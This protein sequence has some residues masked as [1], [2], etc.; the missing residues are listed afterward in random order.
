MKEHLTWPPVA[1]MLL[2]SIILTALIGVVVIGR[3]AS[4]FQTHVQQCATYLAEEQRKASILGAITALAETD[5][6]IR[7]TA[8]GRLEPDNPM[9]LRQMERIF[10]RFGL[11]NMMVMA[12][13][14][15]VNAYR[16][17]NVSTSI[18]GKNFAWRPYFTGP[19][20]GM[21]TM[22]AAFGSNSLE[23]GFYVSTPLLPQSESNHADRKPIGVIVAKLGF[24]EIDRLLSKQ[25]MP[26]AVM[27]PEGVVF[28]SNVPDWLYQVIGT[29]DQLN[30]A[31]SEK[32]VNNAYREKDP[33]LIPL[34]NDGNIRHKGK[35]LS[36]HTTDISWPDPSG[37]WLLAGFIN[38]GDL[39]SWPARITTTTI[40]FLFSLLLHTWL[41]VRQQASRRTK[42]VVTLL[43]N[44]GEGFLSFG[45]DL[46][47]DSEYSRACET[48]LGSSPAGKNVVELLFDDAP[49]SDE[50]M[51]KTIASVITT[52]DSFISDS[53]LSLLPKEVKRNNTLLSI[54]YRRIAA[55]KFMIILSD[56]TEQRATEERLHQE[57][58]R[59]RM[60]VLA[61]S[62]SRNFFETVESFQEFLDHLAECNLAD[63]SDK[64]GLAK[65]IY[66]ELHTFKGTLNQ[67][68]F[69]SVPEAIHTSE[70][71]LALLLA[72]KNRSIITN[73]DIISRI[74]LQQL[75]AS[76]G[77]DLKVLG[78]TLGSDFLA[79]GNALVLSDEQAEQLEAFVQKLL[80]GEQLD[81]G[82]ADVRK[83]LNEIRNLR[84]VSLTS[85][86]KGFGSLVEQA[87]KRLGKQ[88]KP[89]QLEG[90]D[91][92]L[93]D[94]QLYK[95]FLQSLVHIFRNAVSH[96]IEDPEVRWEHNKD[97]AGSISCKAVILNN[98]LKLTISDDGAGLD[99]DKLAKKAVELKLPNAE[100]M[101]REELQELIF[102]DQ[103]STQNSANE[104]AGRGVGLAAVRSETEKLGGRVTVDSTTGVGTSFSFTLPFTDIGDFTK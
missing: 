40:I 85:A 10:N 28:A 17:K 35:T 90:G 84:K 46:T 25:K 58:Q 93:I 5:Q 51:R 50:L 69:T 1:A 2:V 33:T 76:L 92:I 42:Q 65:N 41:R 72:D 55:E 9:V 81:T 68:S 96:G 88:I 11:D 18:T 27:S 64:R 78:D 71:G 67:Y 100:N 80:R 57:Q 4:E 22:Y 62:D 15:T 95:Q 53:M 7:D 56:V 101:T 79:Q 19:M 94:P 44:S 43:N 77:T 23:R 24:D 26:F 102:M 20:Q 99:F 54:E 12:G 73:C 34:S 87:G 36:I 8:L 32:R 59:L 82:M 47:I 14:G 70:A 38:D 29:E 30:R 91:N 21:Q 52:R 103:F 37:T 83:L 104:F 60:I 75:Q 74:N 86:L 63:K 66:R 89:L 6:T 98:R 97:E 48:M 61:V 13:D 31:R 3:G 39:F 49:E 16:V 45:R